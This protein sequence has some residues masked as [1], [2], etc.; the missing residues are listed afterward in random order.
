LGALG[1]VV[2]KDA[3]GLRAELATRPHTNGVVAAGAIDQVAARKGS[4][5]ADRLAAL[6]HHHRSA[7]RE[8]ARKLNA[9]QSEKD[10]GPF[11][12]SNAV[13]SEPVRKLMED[14]LALMPGLPGP[15]AEFVTVTVRYLDDKKVTKQTSDETGWLVRR[16]K[17]VVEVYTPYGRTEVARPGER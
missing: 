9:Q 11:D 8:A 2:T 1:K 6:C 16:E 4:L 14:L 5:P 3:D 17:D 15:K 13:L 7:I 10:P 12:P